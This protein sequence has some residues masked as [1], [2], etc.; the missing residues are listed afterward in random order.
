MIKDFANWA[1][2]KSQIGI[3]F[4]VPFYSVQIRREFLTWVYFLT[5][6]KKKQQSRLQV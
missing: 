6:R 2:K 1:L 4:V 5:R 3:P